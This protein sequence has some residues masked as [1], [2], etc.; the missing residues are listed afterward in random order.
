MVSTPQ[1][2]S[3]LDAKKSLNMAKKL[4]INIVGLVENMSGEIFGRGQL[5]KVAK[6]L[7]IP[8]LG[9]IELHKSYSRQEKD[10][11]PAVLTSKKLQTIFEKIVAAITPK[12]L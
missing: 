1:S 4:N 10:G 11:K 3:I 9:S 12:I 7:N 6:E 8:Y 2:L 5:P